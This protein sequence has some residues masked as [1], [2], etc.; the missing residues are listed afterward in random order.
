MFFE[1]LDD[2]YTRQ[3]LKG[4]NSIKNG[5]LIVEP[6]LIWDA[7]GKGDSKLFKKFLKIPLPFHVMVNSGNIYRP[8]SPQALSELIIN[9]I[10][11]PQYF[12]EVN[13]LGSRI[14][15]LF[16]LFKIMGSRM[17]KTIIPINSFFILDK[18]YLYQ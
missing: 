5:F 17:N 13:V 10:K 3:K 16:E 9:N 15:S 8:I 7:S 1:F 14:L 4:E 18:I 11:N 2:I 12:N 6:G